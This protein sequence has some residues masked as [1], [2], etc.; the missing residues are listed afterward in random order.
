MFM[1][2]VSLCILMQFMEWCAEVEMQMEGEQ[3]KC[4]RCSIYMYF[5]CVHSV[6]I[7]YIYNVMYNVYIQ[8]YNY[9]VWW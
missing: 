7:H 1:K 5:T 2:S 6:G 4:Y 8:Y 3:D 9:T